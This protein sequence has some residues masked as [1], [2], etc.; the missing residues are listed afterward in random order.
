MT[1]AVQ[2]KCSSSGISAIHAK[3]IVSNFHDS[4]GWDA[5]VNGLKPSALLSAGTWNEIVDI[6]ASSLFEAGLP[7]EHREVLGWHQNLGDIHSEDL[8]LIK[9]MPR[10]LQHL[11]HHGIIISICTSDDRVA[12]NA[13][14]QNWGIT[15]LVDFSICGDEVGDECKP[16]PQPLFEL[17]RRAGLSPSECFVVGDTSND[18][19]M[20]SR[21]GA[22]FVV[23]VLTGSGTTEQLL[24][25]GADIVLPNVGYLTDLLLLS[26]EPSSSIVD[27][28]FPLND[29][30]V[31]FSDEFVPL[32]ENMS[33]IKKVKAA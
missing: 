9:N 7:I 16:S 15:D 5:T 22:G 3:K 8:P 23:G 6:S 21:S 12:T 2:H 29:E 13:C 11:K 26:A 32:N 10:F 31:S 30:L 19:K 24:E 25:T 4:I 33:P 1:S 14:M 20:G 18:T 27:E 17:C 28:F